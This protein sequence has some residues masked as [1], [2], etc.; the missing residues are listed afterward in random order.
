MTRSLHVS[1]P[2]LAI[3]TAR[4]L[5]LAVL[6][7]GA[8]QSGLKARPPRDASSGPGADATQPGG[9]AG[10]GDVAGMGS[11]GA[12]VP[13]TGGMAAGGRATGGGAG[14]NGGKTAGG[15]ATGGNGG[16]GT[17]GTPVDCDAIAAK[18]AGQT[19]LVGTCTAVVRLDYATL[20]IIS[21]AFVCGEYTPTD[22]AAA[23][24]TA[25]A[26]AVFPY[27]A[28]AGEG[29]L[30]SG[31]SPPDEWVFY[32]APGDFGGAAAVSARS[33]LTVFAGSIVWM[34]TGKITVPATWD[35]SD[36]GPGCGQ[37][38]GWSARGFDL[39]G[40]EAADRMR[41]AADVVLATALPSAFSRWGGLLD[42]VVLLY[43]RS[44]GV[45]DPATAEYVVL[46]NAGWLE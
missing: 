13:G 32:Q 15:N 44:V 16:S 37:P 22:E 6:L 29:R 21:H 26:D 45:F 11:G 4:L 18:I 10:N 39:S 33:G 43:P 8:C 23:R 41:E 28:P 25:S 34:G 9:S 19:G 31:P 12:A 24:K 46:L 27:A 35:T 3:S 40:G 14:G 42:V 7:P 20:A 36:L 2:H 5:A 1:K 30:L 38:A 17:G